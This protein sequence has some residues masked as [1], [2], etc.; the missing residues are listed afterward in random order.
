MCVPSSCTNEEVSLALKDQLVEATRI[1]EANWRV[2][3]KRGMCQ[4]RD[5]QWIQNLDSKVITAM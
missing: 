3:V 4:V 5:D 1:P 2:E